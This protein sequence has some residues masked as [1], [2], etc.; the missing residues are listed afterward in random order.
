MGYKNS[1]GYSKH[2][3]NCVKHCIKKKRCIWTISYK[4]HSQEIQ[5]KLLSVDAISD[6]RHRTDRANLQN[7][8]P[9]TPEQLYVHFCRARKCNQIIPNSERNIFLIN[10]SKRV[11]TEYHLLRAARRKFVLVA[12]INCT[13]YV[14]ENEP[15]LPKEEPESKKKKNRQHTP[16][17]TK[18]R[19]NLFPW[20]HLSIFE[21]ISSAKLFHL[22]H[23]HR[24]GGRVWVMDEEEIS[25][26]FHFKTIPSA[27][28]AILSK[29]RQRTIYVFNFKLQDI[30]F[31]S[32][33]RVQFWIL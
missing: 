14:H 33:N 9:H 29:H 16:T 7:K 5:T 11:T 25:R 26:H 13:W 22:V 10:L 6:Q 31:Q 15:S 19:R 8:K 27:T 4:N 1:N 23:L 12:S 18:T 30:L 21:Q 2:P 28:P 24:R 32:L 17:H 3:E 20:W